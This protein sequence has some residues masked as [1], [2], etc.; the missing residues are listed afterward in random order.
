[1][2]EYKS[3]SVK[4]KKRLDVTGLASR[5]NIHIPSFYVEGNFCFTAGCAL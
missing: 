2:I 3:V 5:G 4:K 1:M